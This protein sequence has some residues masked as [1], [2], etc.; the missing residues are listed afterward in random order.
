VILQRYISLYFDLLFSSQSALLVGLMVLLFLGEQKSWLEK[1]RSCWPV[2]LMGLAGLGMYALVLVEP[3]YIAAFFTLFWVGLFSGIVIPKGR[4]AVR[5]APLITIIVVFVI[6]APVGLFGESLAENPS[7]RTEYR[8][9]GSPEPG[10]L[11]C[12]TRRIT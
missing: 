1:I 6:A 8:L 3:R 9:A 12:Q 10:T 4:E 7:R 11:W 5:T 2:W